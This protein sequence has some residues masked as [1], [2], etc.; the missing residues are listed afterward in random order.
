MVSQQPS[1]PALKGF[2]GDSFDAREGK[3]AYDEVGSSRVPNSFMKRNSNH[4]HTDV[5]GSWDDAPKVEKTNFKGFGRPPGII[6]TNVSGSMRTS[7]LGKGKQ[8]RF[9]SSRQE[10]KQEGGSKQGEDA[11][12]DNMQTFRKDKP[13]QIA[14]DVLTICNVF[15]KPNRF[16][17]KGEGQLVSSQREKEFFSSMY[18]SI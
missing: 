13:E 9:K 16:L 11:E 7:P 18:Q 17:K 14:K 2:V 6:K 8:L 5:K 10:A 3:Q 1:F 15:H 12:S 4:L